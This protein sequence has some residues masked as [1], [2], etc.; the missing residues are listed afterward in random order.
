MVE[1]QEPSS[2]EVF[3]RL[4]QKNGLFVAIPSIARTIKLKR[5]TNALFLSVR[6]RSVLRV[7]QPQENR[8]YFFATVTQ[9]LLADEYKN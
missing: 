5:L 8:L 4:A 9:K 3:C 1:P 2:W 6:Q 7:F